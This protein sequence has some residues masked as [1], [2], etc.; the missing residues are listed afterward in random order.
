MSAAEYYYP[1]APRGAPS[2]SATNPIQGRRP[3][4]MD[5]STS[6]QIVYD[7]RWN[8]EYDSRVRSRESNRLAQDESAALA[9][10]EELDLAQAIA[11]STHT[12]EREANRRRREHTPDRRQ[13]SYPMHPLRAAHSN[14]SNSSARSRHQRSTPEVTHMSSNTSFRARRYVRHPNASPAE[15][16]FE[17]DTMFTTDFRCPRCGELIVTSQV[18]LQVRSLP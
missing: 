14:S 1:Y 10:Q 3:S 13:T 11:N 9:M 5:P 4:P 17:Y 6:H 18:Q 8:R 7:P 12:A 2:S 16:L 15:K